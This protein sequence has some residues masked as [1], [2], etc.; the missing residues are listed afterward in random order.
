VDNRGNAVI[1]VKCSTK[2]CEPCA[3]LAQ[4]VRSK[5]R[6]PRRTLTIRPQRRYQALQAARQREATD[7]F[8]AA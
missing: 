8:Q 1:K 5:K 6:Y 3:K 7:G 2:D 4:C